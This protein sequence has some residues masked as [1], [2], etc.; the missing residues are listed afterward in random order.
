[1]LDTDETW[2]IV[3]DDP[4]EGVQCCILTYS[5]VKVGEKMENVILTIAKFQIS[6]HFPEILSVQ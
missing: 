6:L 3:R 4:P 1:M 2:R 5:I